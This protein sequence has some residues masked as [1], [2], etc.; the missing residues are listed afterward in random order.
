MDGP[1]KRV[2][3][4]ASKTGSSNRL[5][6]PMCDCRRASRPSGFSFAFWNLKF[7]FQQQVPGKHRRTCKFFGIDGQ[8]QRRV[9][10]QFPL[11]LAWFSARMTLACMEYA[12]GTSSPGCSVR[13]KNVVPGRYSPVLSALIETGENILASRSVSET[14]RLLEGT[15]REILSLY[16]ERRASPGDVDESG[17][18]HMRVGIGKTTLISQV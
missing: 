5:I 3:H 10:A 1:P 12:M 8:T 17:R 7:E 14:I 11:K 15:E 4:C 2:T 16:R 9:N 13:F 18:C 6:S